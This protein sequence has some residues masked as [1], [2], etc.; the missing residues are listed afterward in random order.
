[1]KLRIMFF[2]NEKLEA[3]STKWHLVIFQNSY[4]TSAI[5]ET[6]ISDDGWT[7]VSVSKTAERIWI[8]YSDSF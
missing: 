3:D 6:K 4:L 5:N 8:W 2:F 7:F 1:M